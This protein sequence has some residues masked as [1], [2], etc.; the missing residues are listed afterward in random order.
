MRPLAAV[1]T[2]FAIKFVFSNPNQVPSQSFDF[3]DTTSQELR[4]IE[5]FRCVMA[6]KLSEWLAENFWK[7]QIPQCGSYEPSVRHAMIAVGAMR[8]QLAILCSALPGDPRLDPRALEAQSQF[9]DKHYN[10]AISELSRFLAERPECSEIALINSILFVILDRLRGNFSTAVLHLHN[11]MEILGRWQKGLDLS[12]MA[13]G[14][15]ESNILLVFHH[16]SFQTSPNE[17]HLS[18]KTPDYSPDPTRFTGLYEA[19]ICIQHLLQQ[20]LRLIRLGAVRSLNPQD[21]ESLADLEQDVQEHMAKLDG[22]SQRLNMLLLSFGDNLTVEEDESIHE[23]RG[24]HLVSLMWLGAGLGCTT[25]EGKDRFHLI[26]DLA[27]NL[28]TWRYHRVLPGNWTE[29]AWHTGIM[30]PVHYVAMKCQD[31][32]LRSRAKGIL[33]EACPNLGQ[34]DRPCFQ[35]Q[36]AYAYKSIPEMSYCRS[37][38]NS[39]TIVLREEK[40]AWDKRIAMEF[41]LQP[42]TQLVDLILTPGED[43]RAWEVKKSISQPTGGCNY[44]HYG[45]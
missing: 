18:D 44:G 3:P 19:R 43:G 7:Y 35:N 12:M 33:I 36:T 34:G 27:E 5:Y 14:S 11:G 13:E 22:W 20:S 32:A 37:R 24:I 45:L 4:S 2:S 9:A 10:I 17:Y 30:P 8:E 31:P 28:Q 42:N 15:L 25:S 39:D 26:V 38:T 29:F 16:L 1:P 40:T 23:L 41:E 6:D 21:L